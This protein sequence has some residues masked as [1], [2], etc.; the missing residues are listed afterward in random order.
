MSA[1]YDVKRAIDRSSRGGRRIPQD[2]AGM[3]VFKK[4]NQDEYNV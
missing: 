4:T 1:G 3:V 2:E